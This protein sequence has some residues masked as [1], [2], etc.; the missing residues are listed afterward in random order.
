MSTNSTIIQV[1]YFKLVYN[2]NNNYGQNLYKL[3]F[4]CLK[5][6]YHFGTFQSI[7]STF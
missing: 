2:L 5:Y 1:L 6:N 7:Y 3:L 4:F